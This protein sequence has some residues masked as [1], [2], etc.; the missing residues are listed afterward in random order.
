[1]H[2]ALLVALLCQP[3]MS[4]PMK[5]PA[6]ALE[7]NLVAASQGVAVP[8]TLSL[9]PMA[10]RRDVGERRRGGVAVG[11]VLEGGRC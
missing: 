7:Y 11:D 8:S 1:M 4:S 10:V 5:R 2:V 3:G 6:A 9:H